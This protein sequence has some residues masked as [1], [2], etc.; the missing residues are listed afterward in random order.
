MKKCLFLTLVVALCATQ[1]SFA[2]K[3]E[4]ESKET[5]EQIEKYARPTDGI[6]SSIIMKH[7]TIWSKRSGAQTVSISRSHGESE[8]IQLEDMEMPESAK[9][10]GKLAMAERNPI[11]GLITQFARDGYKMTG[12]SSHT[13]T[14]AAGSTLIETSYTFIKY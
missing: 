2:Q 12:Q 5:K 6:G 14:T 9:G 1:M 7:L 4:K 3:R 10:L 8:L 13:F 11:P